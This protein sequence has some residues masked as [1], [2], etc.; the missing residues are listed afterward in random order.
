M[1]IA[2]HYN[3]HAGLVKPLPV[4]YG[5]EHAVVVGPGLGVDLNC[6][7]GVNQG[8]NQLVDPILIPRL[9]LYA[10]MIVRGVVSNLVKMA[11]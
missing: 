10:G 11:Y 5:R 8:V 2:V 1:G 7:A 4:A 3:R 9:M 6:Q